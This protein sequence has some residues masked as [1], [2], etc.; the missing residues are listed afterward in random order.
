MFMI[1]LLRQ[2]FGD[3]FRINRYL[4]PYVELD[5]DLVN[6]DEIRKYIHERYGND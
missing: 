1:E 3:E 5:D 2:Q 4:A 6:L